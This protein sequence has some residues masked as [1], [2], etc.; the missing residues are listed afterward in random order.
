MAAEL[1]KTLAGFKCSRCGRWG[2][3]PSRMEGLEWSHRVKR[4]ARSVRWDMDNCDCLCRDCH[5]FFESRPLAYAKF[6]SA[7]ERINPADPE[8]LELRGNKGWDRDYG[9]VIVML[10]EALAIARTRAS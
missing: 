6:Y 1:C 8:A 3:G 7:P 2:T 5:E 9:K 4:K 10:S